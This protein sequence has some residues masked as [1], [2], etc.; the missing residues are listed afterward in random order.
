[1]LTVDL[2]QTSLPHVTLKFQT[3]EALNA[4]LR[5]YVAPA[6]TITQEEGS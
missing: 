2:T 3:D 4:W 1:M 5:N 6:V